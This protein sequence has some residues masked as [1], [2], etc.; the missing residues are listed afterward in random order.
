MTEQSSPLEQE[1]S[2]ILPI[3]FPGQ[4]AR[5]AETVGL[6]SNPELRGQHPFL[7]PPNPGSLMMLLHRPQ[8]VWKA[9][10]NT[11]APGIVRLSNS[12]YVFHSTY[13]PRFPPSQQMQYT[14]FTC[15]SPP[16]CMP[17]SGMLAVSHPCLELSVTYKKAWGNARE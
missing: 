9:Q 4:L 6:G 12:L 17:S 14:V 15:T 10:C 16:L 5:V 11:V 8:L 3:Q 2:S 7:L 13:S 1:A